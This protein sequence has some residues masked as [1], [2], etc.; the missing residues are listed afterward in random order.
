MIPLEA[1]DLLIA[2]DNP[3][4][5]ELTLRALKKGNIDSRFAGSAGRRP[6]EDHRG[7]GNRKQHLYNH[8]LT[9]PRHLKGR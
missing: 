1:V 6:G 3:H 4:D 9:S 7:A 5:L 8:N 2:E